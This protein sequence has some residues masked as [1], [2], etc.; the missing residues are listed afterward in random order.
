MNAVLGTVGVLVATVGSI[1]TAAAGF[2]VLAGLRRDR[3]LQ[4][5]LRLLLWGAV[6]A[7][8]ALELGLLTDDFS[9]AYLANHHA[10]TT[11]LLFTIASAWG[12]LEGSIVLWGLVLAGFT[13]IAGRRANDDLDAVAMGY[14]GLISL[15]FFGM[16]L[17]ISNPFEVCTQAAASGVGC[18]D[19]SP[20]PWAQIN[21][22]AEGRGPNPLLQNHILMAVHPPM[23]YVG[24]VGLAI[25]YAFAMAALSL[26]ST[27]IEWARR[28]RRWTMVA[29]A[30]LTVGIVLGGWWSYEVLGWGGYWAWDPVE[31]ASFLPWL[32]ATAFIHSS[33]VQMRRGM[34]QSWNLVLVIS[35]FALTILGT[36]LTRSGAVLS[37][38]SFTQSAVGPVL[39]VFLGLV[40]IGSF[41]LFAARSHLVAQSPRLESLVSREGAFLVN[42]D[43]S[44]KTNNIRCQNCDEFT[45]GA[46]FDHTAPKYR[47]RAYRFTYL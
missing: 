10:S 4:L 13:Y 46:F 34:L 36:F 15:F 40:L 14:L 27:G 26:K 43:E 17:T 30:F 18:V 22:P 35:T 47:Y 38:H 42:S 2:G 3:W 28:T 21:V 12:A 32:T 33:L 29:W 1:L 19:S 24:Y 31:N 41:S 16:M 6:V 7:M 8:V 5:G 25:P 23:L 9:I 11:P 37:V 44:A 45:S 20:F 39:L